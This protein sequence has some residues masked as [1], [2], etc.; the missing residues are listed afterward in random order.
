MLTGGDPRVGELERQAMVPAGVRSGKPVGKARSPGL[1]ILWVFLTLGIYQIIWG[2]STFEE[3]RN[4]RGQGWS[5]TLYLIFTFLFPFPLIAV[6][7]LLPAYVGRMY[8]E[9]GRPS[10]ITGLAGFWT[11]L[12]FI[13]AFIWFFKVQGHLNAFWNEHRRPLAA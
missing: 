3:L 10:P 2:Y 4:Y 7:W 13:G 9:E 8:A 5:G 11:F 6:P 12:P 1:A